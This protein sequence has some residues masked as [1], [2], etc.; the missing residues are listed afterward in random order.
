[1]RKINPA[2]RPRGAPGDLQD[3]EAEDSPQRSRRE[4]QVGQCDDRI[5]DEGSARVAIA[6]R[7]RRGIIKSRQAAGSRSRRREACWAG[8]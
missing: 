7:P 3:C 2:C 4:E 8:S 1:M 5:D 6:V